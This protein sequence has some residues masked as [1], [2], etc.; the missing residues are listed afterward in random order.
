MAAQLPAVAE[1]CRGADRAVEEQNRLFILPA[2]WRR[3]LGS[4]QLG[5][6]AGAGPGGAVSWRGRNVRQGSHGEGMSCR[7]CPVAT[8]RRG[9]PCRKCQEG[10]ALL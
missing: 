6:Q 5:V 10:S 9:L 8:A 7:N 2:W 1:T 4:R 3:T